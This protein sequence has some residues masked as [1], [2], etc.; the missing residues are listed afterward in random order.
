M[1]SIY[2]KKIQNSRQ[3]FQKIPDRFWEYYALNYNMD[4]QIYIFA[5]NIYN[6]LNSNMYYSML[7][8]ILVLNRQIN[9]NSSTIWHKRDF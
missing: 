5:V 3:N 9:N 1:Y 6:Y 2:F 4:K 8:M 7:D